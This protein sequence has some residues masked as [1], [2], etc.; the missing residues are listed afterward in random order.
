MSELEKIAPDGDTPLTTAVE[1]AADA[2]DFREKPGTIVLVTDGDETCGGDPCALARKLKA[3]GFALTVHVIGFK[4][5]SKFFSWRSQADHNLF[6]IPEMS[7]RCLA[8]ATK[9]EFITAETTDELVAALHRTL[10]CP[11]MTDA[12]RNPAQSPSVRE[13]IVQFGNYV[14]CSVKRKETQ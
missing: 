5:R 6:E 8:S 4:A 14:S 3:D 13:P 2:L 11:V 12:P 1:A 7:A 10:G 9:G